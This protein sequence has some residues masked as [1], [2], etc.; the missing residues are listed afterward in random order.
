MDGIDGAFGARSV[1]LVYETIS[2]IDIAKT[3]IVHSAHDFRFF[4]QKLLPTVIF[5]KVQPII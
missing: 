1:D 5:V 3:V 4:Y 2:K